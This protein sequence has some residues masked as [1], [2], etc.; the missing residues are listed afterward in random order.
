MKSKSAPAD[1]SRVLGESRVANQRPIRTPSKLVAT[2]AAAAPAKTTQGDWDWALISRV[3]SWV[4]SPISARKI[5]KN[6]E[7]KI[8]HTPCWRFLTG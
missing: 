4:L 8:P 2:S 1:V 3:A 7:P 6:V 5:V